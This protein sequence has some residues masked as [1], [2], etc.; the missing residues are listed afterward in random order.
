[1]EMRPHEIMQFLIVSINAEQKWLNLD[2]ILAH[3]FSVIAVVS[4]TITGINGRLSWIAWTPR[5]RQQN[6]TIT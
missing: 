1:M 5:V 2:G 6:I 3:F 4:G